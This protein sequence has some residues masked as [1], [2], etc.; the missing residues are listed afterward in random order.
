MASASTSDHQPMPMQ[1]T[2]SGSV[3]GLVISSSRRSTRPRPCAMRRSVC[4][5][6]PLTPMPPMHSP[7]TSTGTPPSIAVQ[8]SGPAA[9]AR[10]SAWVTSRSWPTAPLR[11]G[12]RAC[13]RPR[14][15]PWWCTN[16]GCGTGRR[17][18]APARRR[19]RRRRRC[20]RRSR[21]WPCAASSMAV[22]IIFLAPSWVRRLASAMYMTCRSVRLGP[23]CGT[24]QRRQQGG[25]QSRSNG[26]KRTAALNKA[27][28]TRETG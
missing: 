24:S 18:C 9:S 5:S 8:R 7:S 21:S 14:T 26:A 25:G 13:S 27:A 23:E 28:R 3:V 10:P 12:R 6:P 19:G 20:S 2:R 11:R 17:P 22:A 16:A 15:P 1:A 4:Q